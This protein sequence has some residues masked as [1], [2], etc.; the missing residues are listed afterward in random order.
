MYES[1]RTELTNAEGLVMFPEH[2]VRNSPVVA[3]LADIQEAIAT[4]LEGAFG[5]LVAMETSP[6]Q[7][8]AIYGHGLTVVDPD[9]L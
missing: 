4:V 9:V 5:R 8:Y 2:V 7:S 6:H 3:V 1:R